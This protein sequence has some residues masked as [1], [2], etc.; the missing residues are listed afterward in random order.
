MQLKMLMRTIKVTIAA[1]AVSATGVAK[2]EIPAPTL[3]LGLDGGW[4]A[5]SK[6]LGGTAPS[7]APSEWGSPTYELVRGYDGDKAYKSN[8]NFHPYQELS[9]F[10]GSKDWTINF[11]AQLNAQTQTVPVALF[12]IGGPAWNSG[13]GF[14]VG[15]NADNTIVVQWYGFEGNKTYGELINVEGVGNAGLTSDYHVYTLTHEASSKTY[16]FYVDGVSRG[17]YVDTEGKYAN[18]A[19]KFWC[20]GNVYGGAT[21]IGMT[22]DTDKNAY[23]D[24]FAIWCG[25]CLTD[26]ET[27]EV[28]VACRKFPMYSDS[29][30][31]FE[32]IPSG[33]YG[34]IEVGGYGLKATAYAERTAISGGTGNY[35][36]II[37]S[38]PDTQTHTV[39]GWFKVGELNRIIYFVK[40][41]GMGATQ[42]H[43]GYK[44]WVNASGQIC[45]AKTLA[46]DGSTT[47]GTTLATT[48]SI[49]AEEWNYLTVAVT[50]STSERKA[51][52]KVFINGAECTMSTGVID[53]NLNGKGGCTFY[54]ESG[55]A[56]A[57]LYVDYGALSDTEL[58]KA[59]AVDPA[60]A[61]PAVDPEIYSTVPALAYWTGLGDDRK[62]VTDAKNWICYNAKGIELSGDTI[63]TEDTTI[64]FGSEVSFNWPVGLTFACRKI[65]FANTTVLTADCDW[66]GMTEC[67]EI[68]MLD[69]KGHKLTLTLP[70]N[71]IASG[72]ITDTNEEGKTGE[73]HLVIP[74][75]KTVSNGKIALKG[76]MKLVKEGEG[77]LIPQLTGQT[78]TGGT[79]IVGGK[80][81][82]DGEWGNGALFGVNGSTITVD[83]RGTL[84]L[85]S[86][87]RYNLYKI[88][89]NGGSLID[90]AGP[91]V[92]KS[93][94]W[95]QYDMLGV[96][97]LETNSTMNTTSTDG[98]AIG[99]C[100]SVAKKDLCELWLN[101]Y[102]LDLTMRGGYLCDFEVK[103]P[104]T[105][106]FRGV[107]EI[108]SKSTK[109]NLTNA[110]LNAYGALEVNAETHLGDY[111]NYLTAAD[112]DTLA[113]KNY[114]AKLYVHGRFKPMNGA[115][116]F[117]GCTLKD[118]ATLDLSDQTTTWDA[119]SKATKNGVQEVTFENGATINLIVKEERKFE[120]GELIVSWS[121]MPRDVRFVTNVD[122]EGGELMPS[123]EG[124]RYY[125]RPVP[126]TA[127][128]RVDAEDM[129][130]MNPN[131]W[132]CRKASGLP[133]EGL[134]LG[135]T[136][137][138]VSGAVAFNCTNGSEFLCG[139][140]IVSDAS[141]KANCDWSGI[142]FS[143]VRNAGTEPLDLAGNN[144]TLVLSAD[145]TESMTIT[146]TNV[147]GKTGELHVV[148]PE[149]KTVTNTKIALKGSLKLVKDGEGTF[150]PNLKGQTYT[151]GTEIAEG[152]MKFYN[153]AADSTTYAFKNNA[154]YIGMEGGQVVICDG[155]TLDI[156]GVYDTNLFNYE[157][158]GGTICNS[159]EQTKDTWG[160]MGNIT[161]SADSVLDLANSTVF[162]HPITAS[163]EG[164][165]LT[166]TV[167]SGK[168]CYF[169]TTLPAC[170]L[171]VVSGG[172]IV[173]KKDGKSIDALGTD[174]D[175]NAA[176]ELDVDLTV[177]DYTSRYEYKYLKGGKK[178][179]VTGTFTPVSDY[180][181]GCTMQNGSTIDLSGK[182]GAWSTTT[183]E[184]SD[185]N[186]KGTVEFEP[187]ATVN[188]DLGN[189]QL[190]IGDP[191]MSWTD[192]TAPAKSVKFVVTPGSSAN[193]ALV[194]DGN[195]LRLKRG[196]MVII[197]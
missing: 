82:T 31:G 158:A 173:F 9:S 64:D 19:G 117:R 196:F 84:D 103:T 147:E 187:G 105:I 184:K 39:S 181:Y 168:Y 136:K 161:V 170:K 6:V 88:V 183:K 61:V 72:T 153:T 180:F 154:R 118:G 179:A 23:V 29:L 90:S 171:D 85:A 113:T 22:H 34:D 76:A 95:Y 13:K 163:A 59:L 108:P 67:P 197:Q 16:T 2:A 167:G 54:I 44:V 190:K 65:V 112:S 193:G 30:A 18:G 56:A 148:I 79:E 128:W 182:T 100:A 45:V 177:R 114:A 191:I 52:V 69:L 101:G 68:A 189:R 192:D 17:N 166:V 70:A 42:N 66:S 99:F 123:G 40:S 53:T 75:G 176:I 77:T 51:S 141:L 92:G 140:F 109:C 104:G 74:E 172:Y 186:A 156:N 111:V 20:F 121:L 5:A 33:S 125:A 174:L 91:F 86:A 78:Y 81:G 127:T 10:D 110:V 21:V 119:V 178:L 57:G 107:C 15:Q 62:L 71:P 50:K 115:D 73:L 102:T 129:D 49:S 131:N 38:A 37:K 98:K 149:G 122:L 46:Q 83:E 150:I 27:A 195:V 116:G 25:T 133:I 87:L 120:D 152:T 143:N 185:A 97:S 96:V 3:S 138:Y 12:G 35:N 145:P 157:L 155:G 194:R 94:S 80:M 139:E 11:V 48:E 32:V 124:L 47:S 4:N 159:T 162:S 106:D 28:A 24:D 146:D 144:L 137:V 93:S 130:I 134:P 1:I 8:K 63:P 126:A 43:S 175:V 41:A 169:P 132:D 60:L 160:S 36:G 135:V 165:T 58:F 7:K 142:N 188:V 14:A 89:L 26:E 55:V 151:G 164:L